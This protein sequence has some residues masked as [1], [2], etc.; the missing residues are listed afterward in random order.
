MVDKYHKKLNELLGQAGIEINGSREFDIQVHNDQFY[1]RVFADGL[2][3][4]GEAYMDEWWD[5]ESLDSFVNKVMSVRLDKQI[6]PYKIILLVLQSKL[7]NLQNIKHAFSVAEKH[8]DIGN[9]LFELMLDERL[10]YTCGYWKNANNLGQAQEDKLDLVCRKLDLQ[11]NQQILDIGCGWGSFVKF[12]A[13]N[14][15]VSA[16]GITIS[17]EQVELARE[18]CKGL[19]IEIR[20]QDYREINDK[21]DHIVSLGMFEHVGPKNYATYMKVVERCLKDNGLFLLHTI[22]GANTRHRPDPWMHKY[23]F[24]NGI[25]PSMKDISESIEKRFVLEDFHN[26]GTD[27]DKT[28]MAW[29]E[30]FDANWQHICKKYNERFYRMWKYYLLSCAGAFRARN[31]HLWQLVLSKKGVPG[32]YI[33]IT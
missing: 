6:T 12:A 16:V 21:F 13:E 4:V 20:L 31:V 1:K 23:I 10:V 30:N 25:L 3:G 15:G 29:F 5:V 33:P 27:Y 24:P 18:N 22:G 26:F 17:K 8:Y 2:L 28:L 9:D 14:Y 19:P 7:L 11:K 32:G